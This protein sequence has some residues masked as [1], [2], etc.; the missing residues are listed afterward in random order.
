MTSSVLPTGADARSMQRPKRVGVLV[1]PTRNLDEPL[2]LLHEWTEEHGIEVVQIAASYPQRKVA[3]EGD[4]ADCDLIVSI[5]GDGTTLAALRAGAVAD[6]PV[7][8]IACGSLGALANVP[9]G[10]VHR[11]LE[12]FGAGDWLPRRF[13]AL[14]IVRSDGDTLFALNDLAVAREGGGQ[15]RLTAYVDGTLFARLAGDGA[16]V[17]TPI[18]TSGY[19][20]S[21]GG[22]LFLPLVDA[23]VFTPLPKHGG[24]A[25]PLVIGPASELVLDVAGGFA[26]ARL[27]V[28]GQV[29][30]VDVS[31]LTITW[32]P[33][34]VTQ[35]SFDDQEPLLAGL[36]RRRI[37]VDSPRLLAE[38]DRDS[39]IR[40]EES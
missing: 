13:P 19:A 2:R 34:I 32:R 25:P 39:F 6:R 40:R 10:D 14:S 8:G 17:S 16:V 27:E 21:A 35:V 7:L 36:R 22:P 20:I 24:F 30:D 5:G 28:D 33:G 18:G 38:A 23:F 29:A 12:R 15:V 4:A 1:H 31:A 26:G 37:L 11:A 3:A 9:V